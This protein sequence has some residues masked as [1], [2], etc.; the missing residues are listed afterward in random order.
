MHN[1]PSDRRRR[2]EIFGCS[3]NKFIRDLVFEVLHSK[4]RHI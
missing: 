3:D 1:V 2:E 4:A